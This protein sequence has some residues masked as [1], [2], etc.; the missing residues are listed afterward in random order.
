MS[1]GTP[2]MAS[3]ASDELAKL[4]EA[5]SQLLTWKLSAVQ[6]EAALSSLWG[7]LAPDTDDIIMNVAGL[8]IVNTTKL[9]YKDGNCTHQEQCWDV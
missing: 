6:L 1:L 3:S 2:A 9:P 4:A 7:S 5:E 8:L